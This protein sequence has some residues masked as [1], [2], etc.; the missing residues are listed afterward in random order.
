VT[1]QDGLQL[2]STLFGPVT[3]FQQQLTF[4]ASTLPT[5]SVTILYRQIS[6]LISAHLIERMMF[7][8]SRGKVTASEGEVVGMEYRLWVE[9]AKQAVGRTV[10]KTEAPW[11]KLRDAATVTSLGTEDADVLTSM[12]WDGTHTHTQFE[13]AAEKLGITSFSQAEMRHV[14]RVRVDCKR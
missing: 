4:L 12:V 6:S 1:T 10:R 3:S 11:A 14:L 8:Q 7:Q 2:P 5:S 13:A 9:C